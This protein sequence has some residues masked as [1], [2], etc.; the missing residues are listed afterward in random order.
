MLFLYVG[1]HEMHRLLF[2]PFT[3]YLPGDG[4]DVVWPKVRPSTQGGYT[5]RVTRAE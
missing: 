5:G 3:P 1:L 4:H 2:E